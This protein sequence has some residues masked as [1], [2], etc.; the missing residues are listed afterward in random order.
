MYGGGKKLSKPKTQNTRNLF[1]LK[2]K[3]EEI[4]DRIIRDFWTLSKAEEEKIERKKLEQ[5]GEIKNRLVKDKIIRDSRTLFA[6]EEDYYKP[7][8]VSNFR[9]NNYIE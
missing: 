3:K 7:K 9:N 1:L 4:K 2:K 8:R 6:Q 5:K